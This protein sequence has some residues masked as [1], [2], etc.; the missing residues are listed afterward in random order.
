MGDMSAPSRLRIPVHML[1]MYAP[2]MS[3]LQSWTRHRRE[4]FAPA[5]PTRFSVLAAVL[6]AVSLALCNAVAL[7]QA[8]NLY[9]ALAVGAPLRQALAIRHGQDIFALE[10]RLHLAVE[11]I[12]QHWLSQDV[13]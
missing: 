12:I 3:A 2:A 11:P 9:H 1:Q 5:T 8:V 6:L 7:V 4:L 10:Q 13:R